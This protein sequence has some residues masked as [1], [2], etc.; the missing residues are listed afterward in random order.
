MAQGHSFNPLDPE[1]LGLSV[2]RALLESPCDKMPPN[3]RFEGSG[4]YAIYYQGDYEPYRTI[5]GTDCWWPIYV[6]KAIPAGG[7][8][9]LDALVRAEQIKDHSLYERLVKHGSSIDSPGS[10]LRVGDFRC[11]YLIVDG[12]WIPLAES[13]LIQYYRPLWNVVVEG[14]GNNDPGRGR[15][16]QRRSPWDSLHPGRDYANRD[17][18]GMPEAEVLQTI[19]AHLAKHPPN[20]HKEPVFDVSSLDLPSPDW[21]SNGTPE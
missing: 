20:R 4:L 19:T 21:D 12:I 16:N 17:A 13:L 18:D 14:F 10:G 6:G 7:R 1:R 8:K 5:S 3:Q 11:R 2:I 9:G 15:R